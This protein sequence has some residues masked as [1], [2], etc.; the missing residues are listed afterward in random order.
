VG[1]RRIKMGYEFAIAM[2]A[3]FKIELV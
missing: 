3:G 1:L 2:N